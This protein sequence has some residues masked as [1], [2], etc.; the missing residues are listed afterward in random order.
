MAFETVSGGKPRLSLGDAHGSVPV[1]GARFRRFLAFLGPGY[2]VATGYM[3]PGN[4]AT[5]LAGGSRFGTALL[6]V[7]VL[8]SLMAI[9]L[10]ALSARLAVATGMDLAQVCAARFPRPVSVALWLIA[11]AA[12]IATD[13]AEVIGTAIGLQLLFG[14]P[15]AWGVVLTALDVFL[16]LGLQH[17]GFRKVEAFVVALLIVIAVAFGGQLVLAAGHR[18]YRRGAC[19]AGRAL[20]GSRDALSCAGDPRRH[21]DAP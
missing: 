8:S 20:H 10:Q 9:L 6:F 3:D 4:W 14:L 12:I 16:V 18:R 13:L 2:L 21:R 19:A 7:A 11:E 5:A 15:L 17:L 1:E